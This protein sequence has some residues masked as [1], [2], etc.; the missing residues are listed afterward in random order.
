MKHQVSHF[1]IQVAISSLLGL[2][3]CLAQD[4]RAT[5][6]GLIT[7][8]SNASVARAQVTLLN[9]DTGIT[10]TLPSGASGEY[11]FPL[12]EPGRYKVTA[13]MR[14]FRQTVAENLRVETSGDV[15]VNL[16]LQP[17]TLSQSVV[18]AADAVELQ[19]N[20]SSKSLTI[21]QTQIANLPVLDR[22]P[23]SLVLLD[24]A[25]QNNYPASATPFHMW[26][27][28]ELDFGG[29]TSRANDVLID[30]SP[31]QVGPKGSY[32]P[33]L[34]ATQ[35]VV[36]EQVAVDAE[37]GH[38]AGG[39]TNISTRQGTNEIHGV[40][41]YY[42]R[43]PAIDA[44]SNG[45]L[46]S[47]SLQR[48]SIWGGAAGGPIR[49]N[50]LFTF[51]SYEGWRETVPF[52]PY[53]GALTLPTALER[54]GDYSQSLNISGGLRTIYD[55]NTT[56]YNST[57][58]VAT[59]T[60]FAG[61]RI[62]ATRL[63]PTAVKMMADLWQPNHAPANIAGANNFQIAT[64]L[65]TKY[66][67]VSDRTDWDVS[68]KLRVFGR[69]SEFNASNV[70]PDYTGMNSPAAGNG[71]GGVMWSRNVALD[72]TYTLNPT[73]V[74]DVR[75]SYAAFNDNASAP[76]N[77][78]GAGGLANLWPNNPWY[79]PYLSQYNGSVYFPTLNIGPTSSA[80]K[81][82]GVGSLYFQEPHSYN[83]NAKLGK[84][85][86]PHNLKTGI[87]VRYAAVTLAYPQ[88]LAFNF[89]SATTAATFVSPNVN[90]S[91]D[92]YATFLLG[93]PD[94]SS[95]AGFTPP[96]NI[97]LHYY[98]GYV[99]D[100]YKLSRRIT[101]NAGLR[102]EYE[103]APVDAQNRYLRQLNLNAANPTLA[104]NPFPYTPSELALRAQY[105]GASQAAPPPNGQYIFA[106]G[107]NRSPFK[108]PVF[109]FEPRLGGAVQLNDKTVLQIGWGRN[110][111][112]NSQVFNG[113][114]TN[115][116]FT[117]YSQSSTIQASV[118]GVPQT[119]LSNPYSS[120]N[121]LLPVTGKSLGVNTNLGGSFT[122]NNYVRYQNY[123]DG[124]F[125]RYNATI[126]RQ[127]PGQFRLDVSF[128][129]I[130]GRNI[131]SNAFF[132][133]AFPLNQANPALYY[134]AQTGPQF[135]S[136]VANP[137]YQYLTPSQF[138]GSLRS[139]KTIALQRLLAPYPQYQQITLGSL[140][141]ERDVVRN[142]EV[143][144][145]RS[146]SHGFTILGSYLYNREWQTYFPSADPSGG[147][148][149]YNRTPVWSDSTGNPYARHRTVISGVYDLPVGRGRSLL[150]GAN[151]LVDGVLGGWTLSSNFTLNAGAQLAFCCAYQVVSDP[152]QNV[153]AGYAFNPA[154]FKT[155][156]A[157]TPQAGTRNFPGV[158]AP[159]FWNVDAS[160]A[161]TFP[162]MERWKIQ[163]RMEAYNLTNSI[164]FTSANT[165]FGSSSFGQANLNQ[166]NAGRT[167]QY[168]ARLNF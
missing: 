115:P 43:N 15:T 49:K 21:T 84:T 159:T 136:S 141:I 18:V 66:W 3:V 152:G 65:E 98:G 161:K 23:F 91:G 28:S 24:P 70:L 156:P 60:P 146:Y 22:S 111:M 154:A 42:G 10:K 85:W 89:T 138:P 96:A 93:A 145:Q 114:L 69:Y 100:D 128:I 110:L 124:S 33:T 74:A 139:Q 95:T 126:E 63:D 30:G 47:P 90:L 56:Q 163:F 51:G 158:S 14:D 20:T 29:Q 164:M 148:F 2:S 166:G 150:A 45:L 36:V 27:A 99:Q 62:P 162:I 40:G 59:R 11:R 72:A 53:G 80:Y 67:N 78:I 105:L 153:P 155:L 133:N 123:Q 127:L 57:T 64:A 104:N 147:L 92:P 142:F 132:D 4:Y 108:A 39:V 44:A 46:H 116:N 13:E 121:P 125:D 87:D 34:D 76:Q 151:R 55:P 38:T 32:T 117:G 97:S 7:D 81:Q 165:S 134:N 131:D 157:F 129:G 86:G 130:N 79:Q 25:V 107:S 112:L 82:F 120:D 83:G 106:D 37:Y 12:V 8:S 119:Q 77:V 168:A 122:G 109:N 73:T 58:G 135:I 48:N 144:L 160:L 68:E 113:L 71:Q 31:V 41:Y 75:F 140:P 101:I 35:N 5:V 88:Q 1:W 26:Q 94:N 50:K 52:T 149:Y 61:N 103:S 102:Y 167:L 17:G 54:T 9:V 16:T 143:Q 19:L 137:F 6:Q 118:N